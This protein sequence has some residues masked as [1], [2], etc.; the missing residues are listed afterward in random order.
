MQE[1]QAPPQPL[2]HKG[3]RAAILVELK[4]AQRLTA[5]ELAARLG[6]SLNAVR[7]HL[8]ELEAESLV[9][10]ERERRGVGAPAY[11]YRLT[12]AGEA[13]FPRRYEE[14]LMQLLD[15]VVEREGREA[16]TTMLESQ[17]DALQQ[18]LAPALERASEQERLELVTQAL[19]DEG[20]MAEWR[21]A[22]DGVA[23]LEHNCAILA[24]AERFPEICAAEERFIARTLDATVERQSHILGGCG[25]CTY[26]LRF[27]AGA[28]LATKENG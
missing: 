2:G 5:T 28:V 13:L 3:P 25:A 26:R 1:R 7:H 9:A 21:R 23:L 24:V 4:R 16:A 19:A 17:F 22:D 14:T 8:K 10:Y 27:R 12:P 20:F 15:R 11:A 18:R 6:A